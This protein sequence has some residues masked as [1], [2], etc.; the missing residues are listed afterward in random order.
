MEDIPDVA[1]EY[2]ATL[3]LVFD[4][5]SLEDDD[6]LVSF[7]AHEY[8]SLSNGDAIATGINHEVLANSRDVNGR[9]ASSREHS[10][11]D[12]A[13]RSVNMDVSTATSSA[14]RFA[15]RS[16]A[17]LSSACTCIARA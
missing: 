14:T 15:A 10:D 11:D 6:D 4:D 5:S 9:G 12:H 17:M 16:A 2:E 1:K 8:P 3:A 13:T 7:V